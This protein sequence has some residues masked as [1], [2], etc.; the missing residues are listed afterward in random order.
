MIN[1]REA[2][3]VHGMEYVTFLFGYLVVAY[4]IG[5]NLTKFQVTVLNTFYTILAPFPCIASYTAA[6]EY[7]WL[8][9]QYYEKFR[10]G[11]GAPLFAHAIPA[12]PYLLFATWLLSIVFMQQ[13][14]SHRTPDKT[15]MDPSR[16]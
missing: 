2:L 15:Y 1:A 12:A 6:R 5:A 3:G 9:M 8:A 7:S 16:K 4:L 11:E 13:I 10:P 14:R